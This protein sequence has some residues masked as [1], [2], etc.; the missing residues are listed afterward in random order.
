M[1]PIDIGYILVSRNCPPNK[2]LNPVKAVGC[3][4]NGYVT[5]Y[6]K[7]QPILFYMMYGIKSF[8]STTC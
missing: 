4:Y 8:S 2:I 7:P 6:V 5:T 1:Y 3:V